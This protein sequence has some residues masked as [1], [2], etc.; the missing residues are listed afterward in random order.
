MCMLAVTTYLCVAP[1]TSRPANLI[2]VSLNATSQLAVFQWSI[3]YYSNG[4][5]TGY[6]LYTD[7]TDPV[8]IQGASNNTAVVN[9]GSDS[10]LT[11]RV[12]AL[13]SAGEGPQITRVINING[14]VS[15][16]LLH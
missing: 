7:D 15:H 3:V 5:I 2:L 12:T 1:P 16:I 10:S 6:H 13:N 9:I 14:N 8:Q 11:V 4:P